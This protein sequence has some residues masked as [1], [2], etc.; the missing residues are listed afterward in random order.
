MERACSTHRREEECLQVLERKAEGKE[1]LEKIL[2]V[3]VMN[4]IKIGS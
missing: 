4:N 1:Q 3:G 2:N